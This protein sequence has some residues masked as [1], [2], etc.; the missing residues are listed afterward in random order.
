MRAQ[1]HSGAVELDPHAFFG[2]TAVPPR[3]ES[4]TTRIAGANGASVAVTQ[5]PATEYGALPYTLHLGEGSGQLDI[6]LSGN[7]R[8]GKTEDGLYSVYFS[9]GDVTRTYAADGSF[10]E[11]SG[12]Q[13]N[14]DA[15][16]IFIST[17]NENLQGSSGND[18]FLV[19]AGGSITTGEG[20]N[21]VILKSSY[22]HNAV[23]TGNGTNRITCANNYLGTM[24]LGDGENIV[25]V[26]TMAGMGLVSV[27]T[28]DSSISIEKMTGGKISSLGGGEESERAISIGSMSG[29]SKVFLTKGKNTVD[30]GGMSGTADV[31]LFD[32]EAALSVGHV[33]ESAAITCSARKS[34]VAIRHMGGN[35]RLETGGK[36]SVRVDSMAGSATMNV[37][38]GPGYLQM[39]NVDE[40]GL[41]IKPKDYGTSEVY[42]G[43]MRDSATLSFAGSGHMIAIA[44]MHD[45]AALDWLFPEESDSS[46]VVGKADGTAELPRDT[47]GLYVLSELEQKDMEA[48]KAALAEWRRE[49]EEAGLSATRQ[50]LWASLHGEVS[51]EEELM[52]RVALLMP[53]R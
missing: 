17:T 27:G 5:H 19:Y 26:G 8:I 49:R 31:F 48:V 33:S 16:R 13:T 37:T 30:I 36:A 3:T 40:N 43:E 45:D 34:S 50:D 41:P 35:A 24:L 7:A 20:D 39:L 29:S 53:W 18:T 38:G 51:K 10:T 15:G 2:G 28:G 1:I 52:A 9:N 42:I 21:T 23:T 4:E 44:A 11:T 14:A 22:A 6:E 32:G 47:E 12:D 46:V 25:S